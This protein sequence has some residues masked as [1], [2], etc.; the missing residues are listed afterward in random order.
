[1]ERTTWESFLSDIKTIYNLSLKF[2]DDWQM[3]TGVRFNKNKKIIFVLYLDNL[4]LLPFRMMKLVELIS[5]KTKRL[6]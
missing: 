2:N 1:M 3:I 5:L 6:H 4:I